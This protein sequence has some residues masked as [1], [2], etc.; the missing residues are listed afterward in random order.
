MKIEIKSTFADVQRKLDRLSDDIA[1]VVSARAVNATIAIARTQMSREITSVYALSA[2]K[3]KDKLQVTKASFSAE[4][5]EVSASLMSRVAGGKTRSLNL[6]N[7]AARKGKKGVTFKV[8][9]AGPR[10]M[11]P[12][13]FIGNSGRTVFERVGSSR[14][15]IKAVQSIDVPQMF[16]TKRINAAVVKAINDR[17]PAI[18][19]RELAFALKKF[20]ARP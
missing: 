18:F 15:P 13:T 17:F 12:G 14:L 5:F 2:S 19:E 11:L 8:K 16:Q 3:V 6:I 20:K 9:K 4:R 10:K 1:K 7:F